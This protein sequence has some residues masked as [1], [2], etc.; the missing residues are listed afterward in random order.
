M[1]FNML[2]MSFLGILSLYMGFFG[3][4]KQQELNYKPISPWHQQEGR[5]R[6]LQSMHGDASQYIELRRRQAIQRVGRLNPSNI[7][8][9]KMQLGSTTGALETFMISGICEALPCC[10]KDII[11]D[12]GNEQDEYCPIGGTDTKDA[13]NPKTKVCGI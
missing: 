2:G 10:P 11:Y 1:D 7:K 5:T 4:Q 13:G 6:D 12:G 8:E 3:Y 9:S